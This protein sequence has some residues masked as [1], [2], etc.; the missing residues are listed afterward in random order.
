MQLF[1]KEGIKSCRGETEGEES[2]ED[3]V[4]GVLNGALGKRNFSSSYKSS[5]SLR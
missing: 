3:K 5:G 4:S 1:P 2:V